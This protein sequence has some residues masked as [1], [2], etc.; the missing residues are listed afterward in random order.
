MSDLAVVVKMRQ[1][2]T[3]RERIEAR[4]ARK[5]GE[6]VFLPR[7][8]RDLDGE[9]QVLRV[10]RGLVHE[11]RLVRLGYGVYGGAVVSRPFRQADP[12]QPDTDFSGLHD[13]RL[14]SSALRGNQPKRKGPI[15]KADQRRCRSIRSGT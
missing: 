10:L 15:T 13:K 9:D 7:E 6:D 11:K 1:Q 14:P 5:R 4:I 8:F 2:K 3:L 12:L